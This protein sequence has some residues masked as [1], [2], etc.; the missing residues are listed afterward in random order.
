MAGTTTALLVGHMRR[1]RIGAYTYR[2]LDLRGPSQLCR[3]KV[4]ALR[5]ERELKYW[6]EMAQRS[7]RWFPV[8]DAVKRVS[9]RD[10]RKIMRAFAETV[11]PAKAG[12]P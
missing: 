2:K 12:I 9:E 6:P 7:R 8:K 11:M 3:V 10:L 1:K 5:V 4:F